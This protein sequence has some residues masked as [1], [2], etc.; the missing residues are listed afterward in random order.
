MSVGMFRGYPHVA[1]H[2]HTLAKDSQR[3]FV[4]RVAG[5]E[6]VALGT[7][8]A[9]RFKNKNASVGDTLAV[10]LIE[11]QVSVLLVPRSEWV[12]L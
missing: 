1:E 10:T 4:V 7:V 6:A 2:G 3:P 9:V 12:C 11:G 8:F 5:S